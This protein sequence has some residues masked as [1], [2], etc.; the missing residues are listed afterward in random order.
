MVDEVKIQEAL[1]ALRTSEKRNF[2]ATARTYSVD[3]I[4]LRKQYH[5]LTTS[6]KEY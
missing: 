6:Q 3:A 1:E 4:T 5:R 2:A